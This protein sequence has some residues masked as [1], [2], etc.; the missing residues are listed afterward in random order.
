[1]AAADPGMRRLARDA[2]RYALLLLAAGFALVPLLWGVSTSF[3]APSEILALPPRW[4]PDGLYWA[5]YEASLLR[6]RFARYFTNSLAVVALALIVSLAA[7]T[8]AAYALARRDFRGKEAF[9][10]A[11]WGTVMIPSVAIIVPLYLIA[12]D[13]GLY[14]THL[15]LALVFAALL[16]PTLIWLLRGFVDAVPLEL[17]EAARVDGCTPLRSFYIIVLPLLRPG[18]GAAA[19]LV[20]VTIW[21]DFLVSYSL[22]LKDENRL[23]QVGLYAFVT[24]LG[25]EHGPLMAG[26]IGATLPILVAFALLQRH[27]IRGFT[28]GAVKG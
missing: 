14:D 7:A 6:P 26:A 15:G 17:E 23:L 1:M 18:L 4:L 9:A 8:H 19:I 20:F 16:T 5:N 25:V 13:V 22:T 2:L 27:F 3:K 11:L 10:F 24:E 28:G 21:N 12:V